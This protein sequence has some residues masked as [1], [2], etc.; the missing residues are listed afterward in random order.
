MK[1]CGTILSGL[2]LFSLSLCRPGMAADDDAQAFLGLITGEPRSTAHQM[3]MDLKAMAVQ[4]N[5]HLAI[6]NSAG[7]VENVYAVYQRPGNHLGWVQ[8]DVLAVVAKVKSDPQLKPIASKI[9]WV[10]PLYDKEVHIL[11]RSAIADLDDLNGCTIAMGRVQSGS[12]L[13]SRLILEIAGVKPGRIEAIGVKAALARLKAAS[14]DA[15]MVVDGMPAESLVLDVSPFDGLHLVPITH[16]GIRSFYPAD[17]IPSGTY[18]WQT[19]DVETV[20]VRTVLVA[21]DFH[22]RHCDA[23]GTLAQLIRRHLPWLRENGH[24]KWKQVDIDA[25]VPGWERSLCVTEYMPI[26]D[27]ATGSAADRPNPVADAIKA[28][29]RP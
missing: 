10:Y 9:K 29:F 6:Y 28:L 15:L 25:V 4:H 1:R 14:I 27:A 18:P 11:A 3:G 2:L 5:L 13:T 12:Y 8:S 19:G 7:S 22:D 16:D 23:I 24:P 26:S 20:S 17:R 21:Y